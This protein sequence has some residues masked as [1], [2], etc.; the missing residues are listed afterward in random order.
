MQRSELPIPGEAAWSG[1]EG[2]LDAQYA[3]DKLFGKSVAQVE[4]MLGDNGSLA[5]AED[6]HFM[7]R[8]A[9]QYYIFAFTQF[10]QSERA[11]RDPDSASCFLRLL[12]ARESEEP[13]SVSDIYLELAPTV[14]FVASHQEY[15]DADIDIYGSFAELGQQLRSMCKRQTG[16]A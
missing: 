1:H 11:F 10:L 7:P 15:F 2:D 12:I 16:D 3:Y 9:F 14:E 6:L 13:G 8:R 4:Q 5:R